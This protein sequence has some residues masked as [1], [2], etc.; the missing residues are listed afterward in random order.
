MAVNAADTSFRATARFEDGQWH[1]SAAD[2]QILAAAKRLDQ[3]ED[4]A[5]DAIA[6]YF[7]IARHSFDV[8]VMLELPA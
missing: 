2:G 8:E 3:V 7:E 4:M 6:L 5:R 1:I